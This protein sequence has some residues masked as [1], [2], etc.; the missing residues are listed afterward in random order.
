MNLLASFHIYIELRATVI[1]VT[2]VLRSWDVHRKRH[3]VGHWPPS[4]TGQPWTT[5]TDKIAIR[6]RRHA[7]LCLSLKLGGGNVTA[8]MRHL[9]SGQAV[10]VHVDSPLLPRLNSGKKSLFTVHC[11]RRAQV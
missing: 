2:L 9:C 5:D 1:Y 4:D 8:Y 3:D 6:M 11:V 7:G 10:E